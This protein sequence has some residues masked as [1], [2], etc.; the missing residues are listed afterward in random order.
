MAIAQD[1]GLTMFYGIAGP[2]QIADVA[3]LLNCCGVKL[4]PILSDCHYSLFS[5]K[6][7]MRMSQRSCLTKGS[8]P[9]GKITKLGVIP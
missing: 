8:P 1:E 6:S 4:Q 2:D 9:I 3:L 5:T 7:S